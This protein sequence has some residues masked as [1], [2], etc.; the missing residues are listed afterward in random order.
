MKNYVS[1]NV[2]LKS[3]PKG[4]PKAEDFEIVTED[5]PVPGNG[6]ILVQN[7]W[8]SVDPYMR[9]IMVQGGADVDAL[10]D[11][12]LD[13]VKPGD[14]MTG[15]A[16]GTVV[17][18]N[19]P[20]FKPGDV[21]QHMKGWREYVA[22]PAS[23]FEKLEP[24]DR[25]VESYLGIYGLTGATAYFGIIHD[26][27]IKSGD[28][29]FV[30]GAAG[31]VGQVVCQIAK[32]HGCYVVGSAGSD[33]KCRW[34]REVAGIDATI[35]Y[36]TCGDLNDAVGKAFP[37]GIDVHFENVMGDHLE[38]ALNHAK[39]KA[40]IILCGGVTG[41][42]DAVPRGPSNLMQAVG[43]ALTIQG[44]EVLHHLD[45]FP[46]FRTE[47]DKLVKAGKMKWQQTIAHGIDNSADAFIGLF[48]GKSTGKMLVKLG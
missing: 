21:V 47:M 20:D 3:F 1:R 33:E 17:E 13:V 4:T 8:M 10:D 12:F 32:A 5:V 19:S 29:V 45:Q 24:G 25:P 28:K 36:K 22:A 37:E 41:Y 7:T 30:S 35:N 14:N 31:A 39:S 48:S 6:E 16:I 15:P 40:R 38:A 43:K 23:K 2:R 27:Q 26:G 46:L 44:T 18:S 34:L 42:N 11:E 9:L